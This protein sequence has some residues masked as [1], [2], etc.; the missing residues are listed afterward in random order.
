MTSSTVEGR[1]GNKSLTEN[2]QKVSFIQRMKAY[3]GTDI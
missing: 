2:I 3:V 1:L